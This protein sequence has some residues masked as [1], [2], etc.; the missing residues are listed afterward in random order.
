ML[1]VLGAE[2]RAEG[3]DLAHRQ[4]VGLD[5]ELAGDGE[6]DAG[7]PKKSLREIDLALGRARQVRQVERADLEH[8]R[9]RLRHRSGDDRRV[10]PEEAVLVEEAVDRHAQRVPHARDGAE[11]VRARAKVRDLAQVFERVLLGLDRIG[12]GILDPADDFDLARLDLERLALA[13][14]LHERAGGDDRAAGGQVHDFARVIRQRVRRD[15]LDRI[16]ARSVVDARG[17]RTR[18]WNRGGCG[19]S[20]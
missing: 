14:R 5:I 9:R 12:V 15:D 11:R 1:R 16:E 7:L 8:L 19:P 18:P 10:N 6:T 17:T 13:L 3:V 4:A 20:P 2:R